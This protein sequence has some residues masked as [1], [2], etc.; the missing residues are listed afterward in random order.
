[1]LIDD[2]SHSLEVLN[3]SGTLIPVLERWL[4]L[5]P[6]MYGRVL[7]LRTVHALTSIT[8]FLCTT[9]S[10][11]A[12]GIPFTWRAGDF[13]GA[14]YKK[15]SSTVTGLTLGRAVF[16]ALAKLLDRALRQQK[17]PDFVSTPQQI[18][19]GYEEDVYSGL[20]EETFGDDDDNSLSYDSDDEEEELESED[21]VDGDGEDKEVA[22]NE[23][24]R[25]EL[26][27]CFGT[28]GSLC[29]LYT[30]DAADEEDSVYLCGRRIIKKK[31]EINE[32]EG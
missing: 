26:V 24:L 10:E 17:S 22:G 19:S 15:G 4:S 1:M 28:V 12:S 9:G 5:I 14:K 6:H 21:D 11:E 29:L 31:I 32:I 20:Q 27:E 16:L 13:G 2:T 3:A 7:M 30:S 18:Y 23:G 8:G 25:G